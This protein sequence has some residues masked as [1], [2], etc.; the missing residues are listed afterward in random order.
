MAQ[1]KKKPSGHQLEA[2]AKAHQ[3]NEFLR[4]LKHFINNCCGKDIFSLIPPIHQ[5]AIYLMRCHSLALVPAAGDKVPIQLLTFQKRV[6]SDFLKKERL[7]I[8]QYRDT[9]SFDDF[10]TVGLTAFYLPE[11]IKEGNFPNA[12]EVRSA[13]LEHCHGEDYIREFLQRLQVFFETLIWVA[14]DR[15]TPGIIAMH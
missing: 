15:D 11:R 7:E 5:N 2:I 6:L 9:L 12:S 10:L 13:L 4:K 14:I 1:R 3:K 8:K